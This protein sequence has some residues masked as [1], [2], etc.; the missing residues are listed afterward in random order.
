MREAFSQGGEHEWHANGTDSEKNSEKIEIRVFCFSAYVGNESVGSAIDD[1]AA[2]PD[3]YDCNPER[4][5]RG[6]KGNSLKARSDQR[7]AK[8]QHSFVAVSIDERTDRE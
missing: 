1:P 7:S 8:K 3:E 6:R 4:E 5:H 2:E